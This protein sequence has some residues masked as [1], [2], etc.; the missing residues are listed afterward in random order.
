MAV[1]RFTGAVVKYPARFALGAY[2]A[3][4]A[5]GAALLLLPVCQ[6]DRDHPLTALEALFTATSAVCVTG[7]SVR[8]VG[9]DLSFAGQAVVMALIQLG[10]IGIITVTTLATFGR[11][12]GGRVRD[13]LAVAQ[14]LGSRPTDDA[15]WV[16]RTVVLTVLLFEGIG[17]GLLF[18]RNLA[19]Q[20]AGEAA[21][22]ALFHSVSAFCNAGFG[23]HDDSLMRFRNDVLV[24]LTVCGLIIAGGIGFPV[25]LDLYRSIRSVGRDWSRE[26]SLN[27]RLVLTGTFGLL[28]LGTIAFLLLERENTLK[29]MPFDQ[30]L[31]VSFFHSTTCRTAGFNT[32]SVPALTNA[33][34]FVSILLMMVGAAPCSAGGGFKVSTLMVLSTLAWDRIR[35]YE[36]TQFSRRAISEQNIDR[37]VA[38]VLLFVLLLCLGLTALLAIEQSRTPHSAGETLF[39][40]AM[41][42]VSSAL[43]TV[44]L[45]TGV[46][47]E[48]GQS[49]HV[50]LIVLMIIGRLGPISI[51]VAVSRTARDPRLTY[52]KEDVLIG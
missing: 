32:V 42:E 10:G 48:L 43:C 9:H 29:G 45:S 6:A 18:M 24:N 34:L 52:A 22:H 4:I 25:L 39:L 20:P 47:P 3:L 37:A 50:L 40:D 36:Q 12:R 41:F 27:T 16:V 35:G 7:L 21:W 51:F 46:T 33:M 28:A 17:F 19:D 15:R 2:P 1:P 8:S 13:R 23:L 26:I 5:L 30:Q 14:T 49:G 11:R 31:L 38:V 44:G